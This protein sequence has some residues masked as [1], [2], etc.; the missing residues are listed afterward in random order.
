MRSALA[1]A[2]LVFT[3]N[4]QEIDRIAVVVN[5]QAIT[6]GDWEQQERFEAMSNSEP[7]E[8]VKRSHDAL[9]R[10][11][12]RALILEQ[13]QRAGVTRAD[14]T[15]TS[16]QFQ[17]FRAQLKLEND[18][19]WKATLKRY[20]LL[21]ADVADIIAEQSAVLHFMEQRFRPA[22]HIAP[23]DVRRY[24]RDTYIPEFAKTAK[25]GT[26]P[27]PVDQVQQQITTVLAEQRMNDLFATWLKTLRTQ[28]NIRRVAKEAK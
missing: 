9:D 6:M 12:D 19:E 24:Y 28:A 10:L 18:D 23:E 13:M 3:L 27:P 14:A 11:I 26:K 16:A 4:A 20:G 22:V 17:T 2:A 15:A 5:N 7:W 8:G 21:E 1:I 25:A